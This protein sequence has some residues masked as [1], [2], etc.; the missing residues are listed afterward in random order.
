MQQ[1]N[2][3]GEDNRMRIP[4]G[5]THM[6]MKCTYLR[7]FS[8]WTQ[9]V[10]VVAHENMCLCTFIPEVLLC[11]SLR[12]ITSALSDPQKA[13]QQLFESNI[14]NVLLSSESLSCVNIKTTKLF[15]CSE[16]KELPRQISQDPV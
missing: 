7:S 4:L 12:G 9:F 5:G 15:K 8:I 13:M 1:L 2:Y 11:V 16:E 3:S 14:S 6:G 10:C